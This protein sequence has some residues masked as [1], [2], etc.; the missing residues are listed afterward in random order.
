MPEILR[1]QEAAGIKRTR[2][3]V[4][5]LSIDRVAIADRIYRFYQNDLTD[6][7]Q[8]REARLQRYAK[9][10]MWTSGKDWPWEDASDAAV[11]DIMTQSLRIQ[12]TLHNA[13]MQMRPAII[14]KALNGKSDTDKQERI[15]NLIDYQVFVENE[16][17]KMIGDIADAFV[18]DGVM[19]VYVPWVRE[20]RDVV[21]IRIYDPIPDEVVPVAYFKELLLEQFPKPTDLLFKRDKDGWEWEVETEEGTERCSFFTR[22][23]D[24]VELLIRKTATIFDG[25]RP[26]VLDYEDVYYPHRAENLQIPGP[27]NPNGSAHV[28]MKSYPTIDEIKRL[29]KSGYYDLITKDELDKIEAVS[30]QQST[31]GQSSRLQKD[32]M[33]GTQETRTEPVVS[34]KQLTRIMC[35]DM[36][37]I[38]GDGLDEDVVFWMILETKTVLKAMYLTEMF[39]SNPPR[40]PF[41]ESSFIPVRGR[42][43]GIS[44]P[45]LMEG[46]HDLLKQFTD[47]VVDGGTIANAPFGFYRPS[48]SIKPE[49]IRLWPGEMYPLNDPQ[50]DVYFPNLPGQSQAFGLNMMTL[51]GQTQDRLTMQSELQFGRIPKGQASALR[52]EGAQQALLMQGEARPERILRRFFLGLTEIWAQIH[53]LN[54]RFLPPKKKFKVAGYTEP[55]QDP[56][57]EIKSQAEIQGRFQFDFQA[58]VLNSSK[59]ALQGAL[60]RL[61]GV[62]LNPMTVQLGIVGPDGVYQ[63]LR[64]YGKAWG[65]DPDKYLTAP[66][67]DS[68]LP[69]ILAEEA[70]SA[71]LNDDIPHGRPLEG[72]EPHLQKLLAFM[73]S[74][75]FGYLSQTGVQIFQN[76]A[77]QV[78]ER[79]MAEARQAQ[80]AQLMGQFAQGQAG[81]PGMAAATP[82]QSPA[83]VNDNEVIDETLPSAKGEV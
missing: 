47:Q 54:Q 72:A 75:E 26:T 8:D 23:D 48:S 5:S 65:Q 42:R 28:I 69:P 66:L 35:F 60:E 74:D 29:A 41:A 18:N 59:Q 79:A 40:R 14:S 83:P 27:S 6:R 36:Y 15:D 30:Q 10:R 46:T 78:R 51:I 22:D 68:N 53:E 49:V 63:L 12:D 70:I 62:Y 73:Q 16:G 55:G 17:E 39:P 13:V 38:D 32:R 24:R 3:R 50:R 82:D 71:M 1:A 44:L 33:Q 4:E 43:T 77:M 58:N 2:R 61:L 31:E 9:L 19:T 7:S 21:D 67:P 56:Y 20:E 57:H 37:D 76:Y 34:H 25:P 52:T 45:E 80:M 64:D 11:P 81:P